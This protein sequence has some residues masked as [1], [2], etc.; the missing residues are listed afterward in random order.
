MIQLSNTKTKFILRRKTERR[1]EICADLNHVEK[2]AGYGLNEKEI[3][4]LYCVTEK[5]F[6]A[7]QKRYRLLAEAVERGKDAA[8]SQVME[9]LFK[10]ATGFEQRETEYTRHQGKVLPYTVVKY[11]PPDMRAIEFWLKNRTPLKWKEKVDYDLKLKE[12]EL[13]K[14]RM[15]AVAQMDKMM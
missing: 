8:A 5:Q 11:Y 9:A 15:I 6:N 10:R 1:E 13:Q 2:L 14:L 4:N 3:A 12:D 7:A